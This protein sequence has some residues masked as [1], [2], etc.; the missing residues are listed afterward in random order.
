MGL[1][2][3]FTGRSSVKPPAS[4]ERLFAL[5]TAYVTLETSYEIVTAG[6]A[7]LAVQALATAGLLL[8]AAAPT[9]YANLD[10]EAAPT[11]T[12][13]TPYIETQLFF[14]TELWKRSRTR[15]LIS[16]DQK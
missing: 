9:A 11:P 15:A 7:G 8:A 16:A 4:R 10:T 14:G 6:V 1:L 5:S 13:G 2:N 12:R 3:I